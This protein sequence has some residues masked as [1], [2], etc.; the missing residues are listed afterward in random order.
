MRSRRRVDESIRQDSYYY[1]Y[2]R[3]VA[4]SGMDYKY[5]RPRISGVVMIDIVV[6]GLVLL[7]F[8][9]SGVLLM[10]NFPIII[11][12]WFIG[13]S[14]MGI[15]VLLCLHVYNWRE[16]IKWNPEGNVFKAARKDGIPVLRRHAHNGF[17][18]FILGEKDKK[19]SIIF[20]FDKQSKEGLLIDTRVQSGAVPKSFTVGGLEMYDYATSSPFALSSR[21]AVAMDE[22]LKHV[23]A[24]YPEL[25]FFDGQTVLEYVGRDRADLPH[26]CRNLVNLQENLQ[27]IKIPEED[28]EAFQQAELEKAKEQANLNGGESSEDE[29]KRNLEQIYPTDFIN[30]VKNYRA[31]YLSNLFMKIQDEVVDLP[32]PPGRFFSFAEAFQNIASAF[33]AFDFQTIMQLFEQIAKKESELEMKWLVGICVAVGIMVLL[34][35]VALTIWSGRPNP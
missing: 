34:T 11:P 25:K 31:N 23:R 16:N 14:F 24:N 29:I 13:I 26:D 1:T 2:Y 30:F 18:R 27:E 33:T 9:G 5:N 15:L 28:L 12:F 17:F 8:V 32:L 6:V 7:F 3:Y 22:I 21:N 19:G 20:K 35:A 10:F 4:C